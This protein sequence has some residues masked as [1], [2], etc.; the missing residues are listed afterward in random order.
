MLMAKIFRASLLCALLF[1]SSLQSNDFLTAAH[2]QAQKLKHV[3][4]SNRLKQLHNQYLQLVSTLTNST[5]I[6][7]NIFQDDNALQNYIECL[8]SAQFKM[9]NDEKTWMQDDYNA[10][11]VSRIMNRII[12]KP[13][14]HLPYAREIFNLISH[15]QESVDEKVAPIS[16]THMHA[17]LSSRVEM[18]QLLVPTNN[19]DTDKMHQILFVLRLYNKMTFDT[20]IATIK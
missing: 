10:T 1:L 20:G 8:K 17:Y 2:P 18:P 4:R 3:E 12:Y 9:S 15:L 5:H 7:Y 13:S 11:Q 14:E 19:K 6:N 16:P